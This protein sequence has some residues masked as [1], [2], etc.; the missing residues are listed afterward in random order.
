MR[1]TLR[2]GATLGGVA[3]FALAALASPVAAQSTTENLVMGLNRKLMILA[4]PIAVFMEGLLLYTVLKFRNNDE[5]KE[6]SENRGLEI[7]WTV[8]TALIL[9][10]VG[11]SSYQVL[12]QP[13][14]T[15][16]A[17]ERA[18]AALPESAVTVDV[19]GQQFIWR[20]QYPEE[21]VTSL[22]TMVIP[23]N[24]TIYMR[25]TSRDVIH[26]V[27]VPALALKQDA[28]PGQVNAIQTTVTEQGTY[29]LYCAE[30]CGAGHSKMLAT[31]RVVN[32]TEYQNWL[33][34]KSQGGN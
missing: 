27:H 31:V 20:F 29:Q 22:N 8:A 14:V 25:V 2:R 1:H 30:Y 4:V 33:D 9:L 12:A 26:S 17:P 13:A 5:P 10:F 18:D 28:I 24:R 32:E 6:T 16:P 23:V 7:S 34:K 19:T 3:V 21:N 15:A 11:F